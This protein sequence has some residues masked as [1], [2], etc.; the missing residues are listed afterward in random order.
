[1]QE[2]AIKQE[3]CNPHFIDEKATFIAFVPIYST[4]TQGFLPE[5]VRR[6]IL[7][8]ALLNFFFFFNLE[9]IF[10]NLEFIDF[11]FA[12]AQSEFKQYV[13]LSTEHFNIV[14]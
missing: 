9:E 6:T 10:F 12:L 8:K 7:D 3:R 5:P 1:M 13:R 14:H 11:I 2:N 4:K